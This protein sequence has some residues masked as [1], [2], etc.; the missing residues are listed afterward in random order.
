MCGNSSWLIPLGL[1]LPYAWR[2][3][4]CIRVYRDADARPQLFNALKYS[5]AFPVIYFS[6]MKYHTDEAAWVSFYRPLWLVS[7]LVNSAYSY[8]WDVERDWDIQFFSNRT[9]EQLCWGLR[10]PLL[11]TELLYPQGFYYYLMTSNLLLRFT[12]SYKLSPHLRHNYLTVMA[13]TLAEVFRCATSYL[14]LYKLHYIFSQKNLAGGSSGC[15]CVLR[16]SCASCSS[17]IRI[18]RLLCRRPM[19]QMPKWTSN[20]YLLARTTLD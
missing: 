2:L 20:T 13:F 12:W 3:C 15:L 17:F 6:Y 4:Q 9:G 1:A 19:A 18:S 7:A 10:R 8:Y 5:T 14:H 16:W 11:K